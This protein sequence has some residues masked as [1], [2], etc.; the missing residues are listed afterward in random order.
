MNDIE[1][2]EEQR[3]IRDM[4]RDF[5]K[6]ELAP[7]AEKWEKAGWLDESMLKQMGELGFL[8]MVVPEEW[9]G[10]LYVSDQRLFGKLTFS[11]LGRPSAPWSRISDS[12]CRKAPRLFAYLEEYP[13][14]QK[15]LRIY[16]VERQKV[17]GRGNR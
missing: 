8:G 3:M 2:S 17:R 1:L 11:L 6:S 7:N 12:V 10:S 15:R 14:A 13:E 4:A 9:G 16:K 5:A